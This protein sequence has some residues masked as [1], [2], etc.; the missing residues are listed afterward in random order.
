MLQT[1][2]ETV[3]YVPE[4]L[5]WVAHQRGE[6]GVLLQVQLSRRGAERLDSCLDLLQGPVQ[7]GLHIR[8]LEKLL[9]NKKKGVAL[10]TFL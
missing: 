10:F 2:W 9:E 4:D 8:A 1:V 5:H 7:T 6:E 3:V